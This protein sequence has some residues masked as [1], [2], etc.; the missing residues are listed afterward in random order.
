M[1]KIDGSG[2]EQLVLSLFF[3]GFGLVCKDMANPARFQRI[4]V[5]CDCALY[6]CGTE[7]CAGK[8]DSAAVV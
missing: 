6:S 2:G 4:I 1:I 5:I 8:Q 3:A 7:L